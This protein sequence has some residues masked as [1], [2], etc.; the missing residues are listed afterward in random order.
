MFGDKSTYL[1]KF[2]TCVRTRPKENQILGSEFYSMERTKT[3]FNE[4]KI[5]T[6]QNLYHYHLRERGRGMV[7]GVAWVGCTL[8]PMS[9]H[10]WRV[11]GVLIDSE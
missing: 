10:W 4:N 3:L 9:G 7:A 1:E 2:K 5:L 11:N 8:L 6:L